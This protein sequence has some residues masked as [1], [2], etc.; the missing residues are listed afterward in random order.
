MAEAITIYDE[1]GQTKIPERIME[2]LGVKKGN[3]ILAVKLRDE[4]AVKII[5]PREGRSTIE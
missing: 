4:A 3:K 5:P 2:W 1:I